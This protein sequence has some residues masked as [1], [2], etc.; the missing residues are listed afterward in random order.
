MS[1]D[2]VRVVKFSELN[3]VLDRLVI[4]VVD[5][6]RDENIL[7]KMLVEASTQNS[8]T[9]PSIYTE[10]IAY[11]TQGFF[12]GQ[13][14]LVFRDGVQVF[15]I[16]QLSSLL[17]GIFDVSGRV[18][19]SQERNA[20][21]QEI[22]IRAL[23]ARAAIKNV[24][25][26]KFLGVINGYQRPYHYFY[27]KIPFLYTVEPSLLNRT[28]FLTV[29]DK[30]FLPASFWGGGNEV[31]VD[32]L[33]GYIDSREGFAIDIGHP[34]GFNKKS[35]VNDVFDTRVKS[36]FEA[37]EVIDLSGIDGRLVIWFGVCQEKRR[38]VELLAAVNMLIERVSFFFPDVFFVFDGLTRPEY[39]DE[40]EFKSVPR[41]RQDILTLEEIIFESKLVNYISLIGKTAREKLFWA[42]KTDFFISNALTDSMWCSRF[43]MKPGVCFSSDSSQSE[44]LRQHRHP[45]AHLFPF[46]HVHDLGKEGEN[47]SKMDFSIEPGLFVDFTFSI[48]KESIIRSPTK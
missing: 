8:L 45:K 24:A 18:F 1:Y 5:Y 33:S 43:A 3:S 28:T 48:L 23:M 39:V 44:I 4:R 21:R 34:Y 17:Y 13:N 30:A 31:V 36:N 14:T 41:V 10:G 32:D 16:T 40:L 47:W 9:L 29:R 27:D 11:C 2:L 35:H 20:D 12:C 37:S 19:Y 15:F 46:E 26:G 42:F 7:S 25:H 6:F 38:W 22:L